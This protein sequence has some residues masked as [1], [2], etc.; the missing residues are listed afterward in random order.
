M[1][2]NYFTVIS[3]LPE[4][5]DACELYVRNSFCPRNT[6]STKELGKEG[7][8]PH[9]NILHHSKIKSTDKVTRA[10]KRKLTKLVP[11]SPNLVMTKKITNFQH[12]LDYITKEQGFTWILVDENTKASQETRNSQ[13]LQEFQQIRWK[14]VINAIEF[15]SFALW[16]IKYE[17]KSNSGVYMITPD[18]IQELTKD[19]YYVGHLLRKM[20]DLAFIFECLVTPQGDIK[21]RIGQ[22]Y[23]D[24]TFNLQI[25]D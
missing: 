20:K 12:V 13:K 5:Y 16:Y 17:S 6:I 25:D 21:T 23:Y 4:H 19:G 3:P 11:D 8:H 22:A 15:P 7:S 2:P 24:K 9:L 18:L 10:I 14:R 1:E